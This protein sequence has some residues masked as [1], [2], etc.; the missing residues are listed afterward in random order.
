MDDIDSD[1]MDLRDPFAPPPPSKLVGMF[2]GG[3]HTGEGASD[4]WVSERAMSSLGGGARMTEYDD[5][6]DDDSVEVGITRRISGGKRRANMNA[7]G[8]LPMPCSL[9]LPGSAPEAS[10]DCASSVFA[11]RK[12]AHS[13]H[14][15][16]RKHKEIRARKVAAAGVLVETN[17]ASDGY[18]SA[19][20]AG[21]ED[22][23]FGIEEALLSQR[24][25][26]RLDSIEWE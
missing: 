3:D 17:S 12:K 5:D 25:L 21:E 26:R 2:R 18:S 8:R 9:P 16:R 13:H 1:F 4:F 7:W 23:D 20:N 6:D 10:R 11:N 24:L 22:A 14:G 19:Y 15:E